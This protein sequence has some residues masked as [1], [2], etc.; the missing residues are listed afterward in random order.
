MR[1]VIFTLLFFIFSPAYSQ[2]PDLQLKFADSVEN[3]VNTS[4][5]KYFLRE[6]TGRLVITGSKMETVFFKRQFYIDPKTK[7]LHLVTYLRMY[8]NGLLINET[9]YYLYNKP[10]SAYRLRQMKKKI[11]P[12]EA[13]YFYNNQTYKHNDSTVLKPQNE[14][15][16]NAERFLKLYMK[17]K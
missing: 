14:I 13:Y 8:N 3:V 12:E 4:I 16:S 17:T 7:S 6:D 11:T 15:R 9:Y 5:K 10:V 1:V 2:V